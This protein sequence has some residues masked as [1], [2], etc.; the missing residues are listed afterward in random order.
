MYDFAKFCLNLPHLRPSGSLEQP[1]RRHQHLCDWVQKTHKQ[2]LLQPF[3]GNDT[4]RCILGD[5]SRLIIYIGR[6]SMRKLL[7]KLVAN[8]LTVHFFSPDG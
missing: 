3:V 5:L 7:A 2:V 1:S 8:A 6:L 4:N